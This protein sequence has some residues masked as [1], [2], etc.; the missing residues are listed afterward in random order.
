MWPSSSI[1]WQNSI[2]LTARFVLKADLSLL[3]VLLLR[4]PRQN[5]LLKTKRD[6]IAGP[7]NLLPITYSY[8]RDVARCWSGMPDQHLAS[9]EFS[10]EG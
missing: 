6:L 4:Q 5:R 1:D 10:I 2:E 8:P 7:T 9:D 3:D